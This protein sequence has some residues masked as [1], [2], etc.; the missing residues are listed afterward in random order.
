MGNDNAR[1]ALVTGAGRGIGRAIALAL[2]GA[3]F[4]VVVNDLMDSDDLASTVSEIERRGGHAKA[5]PFDVSS[6]EDHR[7]VVDSAWE[8]F[9]GI[10][11]LVNNAGIS[12]KA[13]DDL[14]KVT[15]ES[16][17]RLM[18]VNLRGPFFLTQEVAR[19]M[20]DAGSSSFRSIVT[21]SSTNAEF[22]SVDR[23]EYCISKIGLSMVAQLFAVRLAEHGICSYEIRP[24]V[25]RTQMT[26][27]VEEKYDRLIETGLI[28]IK[29]WG[30]PEDIGRAVAMLATGQLGY[31]TGDVV[32][33]DGGVALRRL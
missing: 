22:V 29:R 17:D 26:A 13:R 30:E 21:I 15:P 10:E 9:G 23:G 25:I 7:R 8:A 4:S 5:L 20:V 32:R 16:Y 31:S 24:G 18:S 33:V 6:I 12:V 14:L 11:C 28:P 27:V 2:A 19:R 3:G 1:R